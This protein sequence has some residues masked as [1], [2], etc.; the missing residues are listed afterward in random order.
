ML[1]IQ[2]LNGGLA[3]Q[4]FQYIF[5]RHFELSHPGEI[6]YLDDSY[7]A[8][9]IIHNG[10]ELERVFGIK[11]HMLSEAFDADVWEYMLAQKKRLGK[12][13]PQ[14]LKDSGTDI[15]MITEHEI[16]YKQFNPFDG[17][18]YVGKFNEYD[19]QIQC[20]ERNTYFHG[21]WINKG[22][23]E[24]FK[25]QF[26]EEF[27]FPVLPDEYNRNLMRR[28][29]NEESASIH[30]RRG[31][32]VR[33]NLAYGIDDFRG[34]TDACIENGGE[35]AVLFVFSDDIAWCKQN[36]E[37]LGLNRFKEV[38]YV[39]GNTGEMS[40]IDMQLMKNCNIMMVGNSSFALLAAL[41]NQRKKWIVNNSGRDI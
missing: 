38:V 14:I 22:W 12:S 40:Y 27:R 33:L 28:I 36:C 10:Y 21:Y 41:L 25:L 26:L 13:I 23:F 7:F 15:D 6:M 17:N 31:D 34:M 3:N 8:L 5:A 32:F 39:E 19:P 11:P 4:A 37:A 16:M 2:F 24:A 35:N 1:K 20:F 29:L 9:N 18:V 30:I